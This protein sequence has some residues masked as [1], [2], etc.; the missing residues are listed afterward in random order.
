MS[1]ITRK[2]IGLN[3]SAGFSMIEVLVSFLVLAAGLLG[4]ASMQKKGVESSHAAY[5]RTQAV[6]MSQDLASRIRA[7]AVAVENGDYNS[8]Q[9]AF[10]E[11]C[12]TSGCTSAEMASHD[13]FEWRASISEILPQGVGV[14][15]LDSTPEDGD[16][17]DSPACDGSGAELVI[18]VW[19]DALVKDGDV[20]Q[21]YVIPVRT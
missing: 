15:C 2:P 7:N 8:P 10:N 14:I 1:L 12:L 5:L 6:S 21:R 9:A 16:D 19:W 4:V 20:D 3:S 18:K 17:A 13:F 11:T